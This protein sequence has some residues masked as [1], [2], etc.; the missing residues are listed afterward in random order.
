MRIS[1]PQSAC[2]LNTIQDMQIWGLRDG[3]NQRHS[4]LEDKTSKILPL[5]APSTSDDDR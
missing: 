5:V 1:L 3:H 2:I 4:D